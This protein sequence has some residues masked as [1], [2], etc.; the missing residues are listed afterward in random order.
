MRIEINL[1]P[2]AKK[3]TGGGGFEMPDFSAIAGAIKDPLMVGAIVAW[4][5]AV[6]VV[7][8][9]FVGLNGQ[10]SDLETQAIA[11]RGEAERYDD[12]LEQQRQVGELR[13]SLVLELQAIREI[14]EDRYVWPHI[15]EEI[16][17]ALPD[18]TWLVS[19]ANLA[20]PQ[21][22]GDSGPP[23]AVRFRV[24][25]RTSEI[26]AY[27]RFL[28]QLSSSPWISNVEDGPARRVVVDGRNMTSFEITIT[29]QPA[30]SAF[31]LT[32]PVTEPAF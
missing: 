22:I 12:L 28:R 15:L 10:V 30:D 4:V 9:V 8:W 3:K 14:D 32:V 13:D 24:D 20:T 21:A 5:L 25:G 6:G 19:V 7:G 11:V 26:A 2:G 17:K 29:F 31:I 1:L 27:T 16:T 18:Y 23:P